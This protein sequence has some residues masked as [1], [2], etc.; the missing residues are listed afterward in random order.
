MIDLET[1]FVDE[2]KG[3]G[4]NRNTTSHL[5]VFL[6]QSSRLLIFTKYV[7]QTNQSHKLAKKTKYTVSK[8]PQKWSNV[9]IHDVSCVKTKQKIVAL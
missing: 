1:I 4:K 9:S 5:A 6:L 2:E 3:Y 7:N 8:I